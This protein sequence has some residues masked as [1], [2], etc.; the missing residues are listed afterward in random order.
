M[1]PETLNALSAEERHRLYKML[2]LKVVANPGRGLEMNGALGKEFVQSE[3]VSRYQLGMST[4][5]R[6]LRPEAV[7][8]IARGAL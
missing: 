1:S 2:Q 6:M 5:E 8:L 7:I 3:P 4:G